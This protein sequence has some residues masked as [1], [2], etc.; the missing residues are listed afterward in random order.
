LYSL[1]YFKESDAAIIMQFMREHPFVVLCGADTKGNPVA[2]Q[3]PVFIDEREG[4]LFLSGHIMKQ[5]D[6]H[7]A[8]SD[9]PNVLALFNGPHT[10]V[11][12]SWYSDP[13]QAATWNYIT[14]HA[15]GKITFLEDEAL[16][17]VLKRTT[18]HF[19]SGEQKPTYFD[20]LQM[21]Y[22]Q[23][24]SKAIVA[25]EVEVMEINNVFKLSQ[26]RDK[27]SYENIIEKLEARPDEDSRAIAA[28]MK[29]RQEQMSW[30]NNDRT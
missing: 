24:L 20:H 11:S 19:E 1:P 5:T 28:E 21:E 15:R 29:K 10:Y 6:H 16:I 18:D 26:N 27:A 13:R 2:S 12:S 7:K 8:F 23:R 25:F 9:N 17:A 30:G 22:V 14:V 4:R 3:I